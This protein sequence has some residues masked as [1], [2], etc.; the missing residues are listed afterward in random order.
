M[1]FMSVL[2][3]VTEDN[4]PPT[5]HVSSSSSSSSSTSSAKEV[6]GIRHLSSFTNVSD[7][8]E[9]TL[10]FA[11]ESRCLVRKAWLSDGNTVLRFYL[12]LEVNAL[13]KPLFNYFVLAAHVNPSHKKVNLSYVRARDHVTGVEYTILCYLRTKC[14]KPRYDVVLYNHDAREVCLWCGITKTKTLDYLYEEPVDH[15]AMHKELFAFVSPLFWDPKR[16]PNKDELGN[17]II[18]GFDPQADSEGNVPLRPRRGGGGAAGRRATSSA[19]T[20]QN[21]KPPKRR[22]SKKRKAALKATKALL[23]L[24]RDFIDGDGTGNDG[25]GDDQGHGEGNTGSSGD[26]NTAGDDQLAIGLKLANMEDNY[27]QLQ[28]TVQNDRLEKDRLENAL[29]QQRQLFEQ[30]RQE[31]LAHYQALLQQQQA[32]QHPPLQLPL[33]TPPLQE[34]QCSEKRQR[35]SQEV[36]LWRTTPVGTA[37]VGTAPAATTPATKPDGLTFMTPPQPCGLFLPSSASSGSSASSVSSGSSVSSA[38]SMVSPPYFGG[39]H[40]ASGTSSSD[41]QHARFLMMQMQ[42]RQSQAERFAKM[43]EA[44]RRNVIYESYFLNNP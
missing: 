29:E 16:G 6:L 17:F 20:K 24:E 14:N 34:A 27:N 36:A 42:A 18:L 9:V 31:E 40:G 39:S 33:Q 3:V 11:G 5:P 26:I 41:E 37:P 44:E 19:S 28:Q 15:A 22:N 35:L 2:F 21:P 30:K 10:T 38:D 7:S 4:Q 23:Q 12:D 43:S 25:N 8:R 32:L 1:F 13:L